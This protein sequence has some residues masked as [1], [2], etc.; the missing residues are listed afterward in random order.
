MTTQ[1]SV[2][3]VRDRTETQDVVERSLQ[4]HRVDGF[5]Q[6][7][8]LAD[9]RR[10]GAQRRRFRRN[11]KSRYLESLAQLLDGIDAASAL[12]QAI[13]T[14]DQIRASTP[15]LEL[16]QRLAVG[17][18]GR[19]FKAPAFQQSAHALEHERVVINNNDKL[20]TGRWLRH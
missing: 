14:N 9:A 2:V 13:I 11:E 3:L 6:H 10:V 20:S 18:G 1:R 19:D 7:E 16:G 8:I 17:R 12:R 5:V 4:P 15:L